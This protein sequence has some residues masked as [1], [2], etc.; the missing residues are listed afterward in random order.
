MDQLRNWNSNVNKS[1]W[2]TGKRDQSVILAAMKLTGVTVL[3]EGFFRL[4]A[5]HFDK[6]TSKYIHSG[7]ETRGK[8]HKKFKI[9]YQGPRKK[10]E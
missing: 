4:T 8:R 10:K 3:D 9:W 7:F 1:F 6:H 2:V 5:H